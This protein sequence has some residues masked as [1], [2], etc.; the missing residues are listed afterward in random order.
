MANEPVCGMIALPLSQIFSAH[1]RKVCIPLLF[2]RHTLLS[3][4]AQLYAGAFGARRPDLLRH[5][6]Q[7]APCPQQVIQS[8]TAELSWISAGRGPMDGSA[9]TCNRRHRRAH[10]G[11]SFL[12]GSLWLHFCRLRGE[13]CLKDRA[14]DP[15][16][17]YDAPTSARKPVSH[18]GVSARAVIDLL[19]SPCR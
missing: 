18:V 2:R 19:L 16:M 10:S 1:D 8:A 9:L 4:G 7:T 14:C 15:A 12:T 6:I 13:N 11:G 17:H 3:L 5:R